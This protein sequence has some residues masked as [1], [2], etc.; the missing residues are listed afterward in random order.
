MA[1]TAEA[2]RPS[3]RTVFERLSNTSCPLTAS[4]VQRLPLANG[5]AH[6]VAL[7]EPPGFVGDGVGR[8]DGLQRGVDAAGEVFQAGPQ[9]LAVGEVPQLVALEEVA[10]QF[11]HLQQE[12]E[13]ALL[14][15]RRRLGALEN[16]DQADH[17][18]VGPQRP[19]DQQEVRGV[20]RLA[21][22]EA[23]MRRH[24]QT[25]AAGHVRIVEN[26]VQH[27]AMPFLLLFILD[28]PGL[29]NIKL[30][31]ERELTIFARRPDNPPV[32]SQRGNHPVEE[33]GIELA[34]RHVLPRQLRDFA[35]QGL[36]LPAA[37]ARSDVHPGVVRSY[38][39]G[40]LE[41]MVIQ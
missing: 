41:T 39:F 3:S 2:R 20:G 8:L 26:L 18:Q 11:A 4:I 30:V 5:H 16:L 21:V 24:Q 15:L 37:S 14:D 33:F 6:A 35:Y 31:L 22:A 23:G 19:E 36:N 38:S 28:Q 12:A 1:T 27:L 25:V 32:G 17:F 7:D 13:V 40:H 10:G 9:D 29:L 34:R